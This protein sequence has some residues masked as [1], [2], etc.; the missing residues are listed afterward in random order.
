MKTVY[1]LGYEGAILSDFIRTLL[2]NKISLLL[3]VRELPQSRKPGFS[4]GMLSKALED[5]GIVYR[6][7]KQLG[8]PKPGRDAARQG[9]MEQFR[10]IFNKHLDLEESQ[11][12]LQQVASEA[13][14]GTIALMCYERIAHNCHR[15]LV[16]QQLLNFNYFDI[17]HL[18][19]K[20][21]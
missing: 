15:S 2:D 20:G 16:A 3:D 9:A 4:K 18:D 21:G 8:D 11:R 19:V 1:T 10:S 14:T 12:A 6:H 13:S 7:V 5:A 17:V